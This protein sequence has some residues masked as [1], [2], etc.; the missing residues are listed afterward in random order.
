[1]RW[2]KNLNGDNRKRNGFLFFPKGN[3]EIRW[4]EYASWSEGYWNGFWVFRYW[5]DEINDEDFRP[6]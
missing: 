6:S 4:L 3:Q 5:I 1:M 2:K